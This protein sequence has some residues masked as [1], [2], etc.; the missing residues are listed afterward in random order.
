MDKRYVLYNMETQQYIRVF[1]TQGY[2]DVAPMILL[3][4]TCLY[5]ADQ[6][7]ANRNLLAVYYPKMRVLILECEVINAG[8]NETYHVK[9]VGWTNHG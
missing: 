6:A 2:C 7:V 8:G 4:I 5:T 1:S 9:H 3:D